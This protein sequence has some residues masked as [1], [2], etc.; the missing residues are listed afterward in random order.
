[1]RILIGLLILL[2]LVL[3]NPAR[4]QTPVPLGTEFQVNSYTT[5]V[6][7]GPAVAV[8]TEGNFVV[9][10]YSWGSYGTDTS[11]LSIQGQRYSADG[12]RLGGEFQVN[13]YTT[14]YQVGAAV[15]ADA[16]GDFVVVWASEGSSGTD[17]DSWSVQGQLFDADGTPVGGE[18]QVNSYTTSSQS[19][20]AVAADADGDFVVVWQSDGS[21][22]MDT[23]LKSIQ[24][25]RFDATGTP[26]GPQFQV[27]S[28]TTGN[29]AK[30]KLAADA[31]GN[32]VVVWQSFGSSGTDTSSWSIQSQLFSADGTPL[33]AEFQV[34]SYTTNYQGPLDVAR[35]SDGR[36]VVVWESDGSYGSDSS[37]ES[38]QG[39]AF[40][41][42]GT[43][44]GGQFQVNSYTTNNQ[45]RVEVAE[46]WDG[47]FV[48]A[49]QSKG[50]DGTDTS[51][52]SIQSQRLG[53]DGSF[54]GGEFQVNSYTSNYQD[55]VEV[56][57]GPDGSFVMVWHSDGSYGTDPGTSVQGQRF[58]TAVFVDGFE[59]GDTSAWSSTVE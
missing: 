9:V 30:P 36:F 46:G 50:S 15:A 24:A 21:Y 39:Q 6:Q 59:S 57:G 55:R 51:W 44:V 54:L 34:N 35:R 56:A 22:G 32:F 27:N 25:Q 3:D 16:D 40:D 42:D 2:T 37:G 1:M 52:W 20:P 18:F 49:W 12:N 10:W 4:S 8:D 53:T 45:S 38:A 11:E 14:N 13:T 58:S 26:E 29:Q 47:S 41:A 31:R 17:T 48:V 43:P 33:G 7:T 19:E 5:S 28:Y 23:S